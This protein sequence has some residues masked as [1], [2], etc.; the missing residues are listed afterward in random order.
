[1]MEPR[2]SKEYIDGRRSFIDF[3]VLNCRTPDE[4]IFCPCKMCHL[5]RQ[6]TPALVYDHL[7]MGKGMW[8]QY[9]D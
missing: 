6:H 5:S 7:T 2:I 3:T 9:K 1:M 4:L 8:P